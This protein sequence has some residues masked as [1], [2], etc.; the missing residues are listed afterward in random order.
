[1]VTAEKCEKTMQVITFRLKLLNNVVNTTGC[2]VLI[3]LIDG[4]KKKPYFQSFKYL[5]YY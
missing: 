3:Q 2:C 4:R 1:M 5:T